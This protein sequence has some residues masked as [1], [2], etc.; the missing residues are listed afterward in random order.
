MVRRLLDLLVSGAA[1][2]LLSVPFLVFGILIRLTSKGPVFYRQP[3][4]GRFGRPF[5]LY[6]FRSM[7]VDH[8]GPSVTAEG[9]SRITPIGAFIR[10]WKI[11]ELPQFW[12]A[13]RGEMSL[14]G[15]RPERP[16]FVEQFEKGIPR[17]MERHKVKSGMSGWAQVNGLR[18]DTSISERLQYDLY[19]IE[20]WSLWFDAKIIILTI[21][22]ILSNIPVNK[23]PL[24]TAKDARNE[25]DKTVKK[26]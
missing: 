12:N 25:N 15:P 2:L 8:T 18:G 6:K 22:D 7:R 5:L 13:F 23:Q 14:I 1:L 17:Y 26:L 4:I 11:D 19:Y 24:K 21:F 20:N 10:R 9:D 16:F 3:R